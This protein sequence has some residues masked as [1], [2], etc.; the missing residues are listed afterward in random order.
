MLQSTKPREQNG[1]DTFSRYKA[2]TRGAA[3]AA[4]SILDGKDIDKVYC[5]FHDDFV[6]RI[7][8]DG[9]HH[10]RF[11]Q[12]K[13]KSKQNENWKL[14]EI[15]GLKT[16]IKD[17]KKQSTE[18]IRKSFIG[19]LLL[20]TVIFD[21]SCDAVILM[22]NVN[23]DDVVEQLATD[24]S[25]GTSSNKYINVM[26]TRFR[27][28]FS[29]KE[30]LL[31]DLDVALKLKKL[32]LE[33]DVE[34]LKENKN[35]FE[36][37]AREKIFEYS[38]IDLDHSESKIVLQNLLQLVENKSVGIISDFTKE[39][40]D[41]MA[42]IGVEELLE[43]LSISKDAYESL[44]AGGDKKAIKSASVIQRTLH[45]AGAETEEIDFC[46]KCKM[47]WDVWLRSNRNLISEL[48]LNE[49]VS[50][51]DSLFRQLILDKSAI[52][53]SSL[54]PSIKSLSEKL[55]EKEIIFDLDEQ[56]LLGGLFSALVR[57]KS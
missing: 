37:L 4:L 43:I 13:T 46:A 18:S 19:K 56:K 51:I 9:E 33:S 57:F 34:Y 50:N 31:N 5:D 40:V 27:E 41:R 3:I 11:V 14:N 23:F 45:A 49:I 48:D 53:L 28:C 8:I 25:S 54:R 20:H 16:T 52:N 36:P 24:I 26:V 21:D 17:Q 29:V 38:E 22:T 32:K 42:G 12:V 39:T 55:K 30:G 1:R 44:V 7:I 10:Y 2:Q 47:S 6:I 15:F 35:N